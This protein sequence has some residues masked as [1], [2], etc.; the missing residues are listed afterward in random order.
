MLLM[1]SDPSAT[2]NLRIQNQI[3]GIR[4]NDSDIDGELMSK[5]SN[6][7]LGQAAGGQSQFAGEVEGAPINKDWTNSLDKYLFEEAMQEDDE[8]PEEENKQ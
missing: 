2:S 8:Y 6:R 7:M 3:K 1:N 5:P 4:K